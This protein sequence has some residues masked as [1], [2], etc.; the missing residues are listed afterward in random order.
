MTVQPDLRSNSY[1]TSPQPL[2]LLLLIAVNRN[3]ERLRPLKDLMA[4]W[5]YLTLIAFFSLTATLSHLGKCII[6]TA[7][8]IS[9]NWI[10]GSGN[11]LNTLWAYSSTYWRLLGQKWVLRDDKKHITSWLQHQVF[12]LQEQEALTCPAT[13]TL[14]WENKW[15]S[16]QMRSSLLMI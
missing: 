4:C 15:T 2:R 8:K 16:M 10:D 9:G 6:T 12:Q 1:I 7:K 13:I 14:T 5:L 11:V 3:M